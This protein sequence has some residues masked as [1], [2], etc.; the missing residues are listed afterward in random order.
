MNKLF[1]KIF[2]GT[3][4]IVAISATGCA[5]W[6]K[7]DRTEKGAVI[8]GGT[9]ALV[10]S[11]VSPGVGGAVVGG[12]VGAVGGGVIGHETDDRRRRRE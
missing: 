2:A 9:G 8:G 5:T 10:G 11:A 12:A 4:S 3:L 6:D 7:L 1:G